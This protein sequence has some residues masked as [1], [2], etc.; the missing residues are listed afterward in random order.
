MFGFMGVHVG[1]VLVVSSCCW[2]VGSFLLCSCFVLV[3]IVYLLKHIVIPCLQ[4]CFSIKVV[5][6]VGE[7]LLNLV[8]VKK[9]R[10][11]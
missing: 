6:V 1:G 3:F 10:E 8:K 7:S 4:K 9:V 11:R 5:E 2:G